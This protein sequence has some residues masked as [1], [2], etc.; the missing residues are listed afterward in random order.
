MGLS[1]TGYSDAKQATTRVNIA[2]DSDGYLAPA[3]VLNA[4][5]KRFSINKVAAENGLEDNTEVLEFFL[6]L[7]NGRQYSDTNVM[8]VSWEV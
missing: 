4:K 7:A 2:V 6:E 3:G 1:K 5:N 8:Q